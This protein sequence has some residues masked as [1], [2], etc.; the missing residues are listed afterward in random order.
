MVAEVSCPAGSHRMQ[1]A[2]I[3]DVTCPSGSVWDGDTCRP[4]AASA[5]NGGG[6]PGSIAVAPG[7]C[8]LNINSIPASQ[9]FVDGVALGWTPRMRA[10]VSVGSHTVMFVTDQAKKTMSVS[11][12]AGETKAVLTKFQQAD[13]GY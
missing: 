7:G 2:C 11:C 10:P 13:P 12:T 5:S 9:T 4:S 1:N 3:G 8:F 6:T